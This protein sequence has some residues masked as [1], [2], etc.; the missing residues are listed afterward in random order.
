MY[1]PCTFE[2]M[3]R[4]PIR[5]I[6]FFFFT[7]VPFFAEGQLVNIWRFGN[8]A[9]LDFNTAIP[10]PLPNSGMNM[11]E[12]TSSTCDQSGNLLFYTNGSEARDRTNAIMPNGSGLTGG[13]SATQTMIV[14]WPGDCSKY[15][16][17][18]ASDHMQNGDFRYSVVDMCLNNGFGDVVA[19]SKNIFLHN[20][21]S[22]KITVVKNSNGTDYWVL[23]HQLGN[24][25]F[26][27]Y[28]V[29]AAGVGA[30]VIT[31]VGSSHAS[32]CMIGPMK[33]SPNG[34]KIVVENT[35]CSLVELFDFNPATGVLSNPNNISS[36]LPSGGNGYYGA[37]FSP[38]SQ[39]L[40]LSST[41]GNDWL[42]QYDLA[43]TTQTTLASAVGNY[44][45]G[46]MQLGPDGK[47]YMVQNNQN[48]VDVISNPN[49]PGTGCNYV[50]GGQP[51]A[52]GT[53]ST[54]GITNFAPSLVNQNIIPGPLTV[55]I[56]NDTNVACNAAFSILLD[57]GPFCA[58]Q[59]L[60]QNGATTQTITATQAGTYY[61]EVSSPCGIGYDTII[62]GTTNLPP[63][64][65]IS[66]PVTICA[67]QSVT[68]F[69][70]GASTYTWPPGQGFTSTYPDSAV[71]VPSSTTT[72][73]VIGTDACGSDTATITVQ[74]NP[75]TIA[76]APNDTSVC[77][78]STVSLSASGSTSYQWGGGSSSALQTISVSPSQTTTYYVSSTASCPGIADTV[79]VTVF[80]PV[81]AGLTGPITACNGETIVLTASGGQN[82]TWLNNVNGSGNTASVAPVNDSA[83]YVVVSDGNCPGDTAVFAVEV[84]STYQAAFGIVQ[85]PCT[86][87]IVF[88][89]LSNGGSAFTW[90]FGDGQS[91]VS[92]QASHA[93]DHAGTYEVTLVVNPN[94][95]CSDSITLTVDYES[96]NPSE[97]WIPNAFTPNNDT[98]NEVFRIYGPVECYYSEMMIFN[99]WGELIWKTN[100]PM[101]EFW[102]GRVDG[103]IVPEGVY[104]YRLEGENLTAR[105]GSVTVI[106]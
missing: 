58:A 106:R 15:F 29:T 80:A 21:T 49:V 11:L 31:S 50:A 12:G 74:V 83:F 4:P 32:N 61:V 87:E 41:W 17:F 105:I 77:P 8:G 34:L 72:Y 40:Y 44:I 95:T 38:N 28:P 10:T 103:T 99:R 20:P 64:V 86:S 51:L 26:R 57:P 69:A 63:A 84:T 82:Y 73:T 62:I 1:K 33:A 75:Q 88:Q 52:A 54:M 89:N 3:K 100:S 91:V 66:G 9:G 60:W 94:M 59:Y 42:I 68:V 16:I 81:N 2:Q 76:I 97:I 48:A 13:T 27:V 98:R 6:L 104:V 24:S 19:G 55:N 93:Y 45:F 78:G 39:L 90:N 36:Q 92:T 30:A 18:Q 53:T 46:G 102:D 37:E 85:T 67:G 22:E 65:Q 43:T 35:F 5:T 71:A 23:T 70:S 14:P 7:I 47:I 79:V 56:G 96:I 25:T 101:T